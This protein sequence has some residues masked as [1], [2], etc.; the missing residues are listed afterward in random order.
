MNDSI[1]GSIV[2]SLYFQVPMMAHVDGT[3][4]F[5][6]RRTIICRI[7]CGADERGTRLA[8]WKRV[9]PELAPLVSAMFEAKMAVHDD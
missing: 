6:T 2:I 1:F 4:S 7:H 3:G 5:F 8:E 9:N